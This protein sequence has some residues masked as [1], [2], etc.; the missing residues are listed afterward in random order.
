VSRFVFFDFFVWRFSNNETYT[1]V[2]EEEYFLV[3]TRWSRGLN[4]LWDYPSNM[5]L[6]QSCLYL[7]MS[8]MWTKKI[9]LH[10]THEDFKKNQKN[11]KENFDAI[12]FN[13]HWSVE[14]KYHSLQLTNSFWSQF[15]VWERIYSTLST[16]TSTRRIISNWEKELLKTDKMK[17][18]IQR[19][20][21]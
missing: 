8:K 6:F 7:E 21:N 11:H 16:T 2:T 15:F 5:K 12:H 4:L 9:L 10:F 13:L 20:N 1:E 14:L 3:C 18:W 17:N 19:N